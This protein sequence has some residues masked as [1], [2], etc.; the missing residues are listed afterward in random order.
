MNRRRG[1]LVLDAGDTHQTHDDRTIG[2]VLMEMR[3]ITRRFG[4]MAA[5]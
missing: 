1:W 3:N 5:E 2:G 4:G